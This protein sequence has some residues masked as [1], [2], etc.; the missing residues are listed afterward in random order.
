MEAVS[1]KKFGITGSTLKLIAIISMLIDHIGAAIYERY[2]WSNSYFLTHETWM[3]L[4]E[5]QLYLLDMVHRSIG[6]IAF[7]IFCFLLVEGFLHTRDRWKYGGRLFAF[8][9]ISE[10]PF[11]LAFQGQILEL[12]YQ[13]VFFTLF[14]GFVGIWAYEVWGV[15]LSGKPGLSLLPWGALPLSMAAAYLI[16]CD[17]SYFGVFF[18]FLMY[19]CRGK[20]AL[21][22]IAGSIAVAWELPAPLA[23]IPIQLYNGQR[24][25]KLKYL[26]YLFYPVHL[27]VLY[28]VSRLLE[29]IAY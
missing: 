7:P 21:R 11:D 20:N 23:F 22:N 19:L 1:G 27:L 15:R 24:G 6:R 9:L 5:N 14:C 10:I 16:R 12:S 25:W 26:F 28:G 8:A 2:L 18:I 17:Y 29:Q 13:N 3:G 4:T